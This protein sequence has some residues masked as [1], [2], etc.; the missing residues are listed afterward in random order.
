MARLGSESA[1]KMTGFSFD[2]FMR[3]RFWFHSPAR[4]LG[5]VLPGLFGLLVSGWGAEPEQASNK[6]LVSAEISA[7]ARPNLIPLNVGLSSYSVLPGD[8]VTVQWTMTNSG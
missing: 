8:V 4:K 3:S 2:R 6:S 7:S 5:C 1:F